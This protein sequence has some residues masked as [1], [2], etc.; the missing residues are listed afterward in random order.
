MQTINDLFDYK[1]DTIQVYNFNEP[2]SESNKLYILNAYGK[3]I[4]QLIVSNEINSDNKTFAQIKIIP[5][6]IKIAKDLNNLTEKNIRF[7]NAELTYHGG[8][9]F[10]KNSKV[11]IKYLKQN[12]KHIYKTLIENISELNQDME[13]PIPIFSIKVGNIFNNK[14]KDNIKK[15]NQRFYISHKK[16]FKLDFYIVNSNFNMEEF[17]NSMYSF[18]MFFSLD[19]LIEKDKYPLNQILILQPIEMFKMKNYTIF[20]RCTF[21][22][23][24]KEPYFQFYNNK[25]FYNAFV[26]RDFLYHNSDGTVSEKISMKEKD[27]EIK[28]HFNAT[29]KSI[30]DEYNDR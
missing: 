20:V 18:N 8:S 25:D 16:P 23:Y 21:D 12:E 10:S 15:K 29:N 4:V 28:E 30:K 3:K 7:K 19:Y 1:N 9:D 26:N 14:Y 24:N 22:K 11:H 17:I 6:D 2:T 27:I 13:I 5:Y